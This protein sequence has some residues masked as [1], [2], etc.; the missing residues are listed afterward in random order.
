M[1]SDTDIKDQTL[2]CIK[3]TNLKRQFLRRTRSV[4]DESI[5]TLFRSHLR[6]QICELVRK[7]ARVVR[8]HELR[9][10]G[11]FVFSV[12][13]FHVGDQPLGRAIHFREIHGV[14]SDTWELWPLVMPRGTA[15]RTGHDWPDG[16]S[17]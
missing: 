2:G 17:T 10:R 5:T 3:L 14:G 15:L 16:A 6:S 4:E 11:N 9:T 7:K 13:F 1:Q 12:Q 8:D